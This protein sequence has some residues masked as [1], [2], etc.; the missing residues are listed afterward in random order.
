MSGSFRERRTARLA[1]GAAG[2]VLEIRQHVE[3][4]C[5]FD[6]G[7]QVV[8]DNPVVIAGDTHHQR[9]HR[10]EGLQCTEVR[11]CF[12]QNAAVRVNQHLG[13]Q[14]KPLLRTSGDQHLRCI[15]FPRQASGDH[16]AQG[17]VPFAGCV[18]QSRL[19]ISLA[20]APQHSLAGVGKLSNGKRLRRGQATGKTDDARL[21]RDF[22]NLADD[23]GVHLLGAAR[24]Q[25]GRVALQVIQFH[26]AS[27]CFSVRFNAAPR[28]LGVFT[29]IF[30]PRNTTAITASP[31][32]T[33]KASS[34][35]PSSGTANS[36][37]MN[38]CTNCT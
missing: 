32:P 14:V 7:C 12:D 34:V 28:P 24:K 38:G 36:I 29:G 19:P 16:F 31:K 10:G 8:D 30:L 5:A 11:G 6:L 22:Q 35:S 18:L 21:L 25:P 37:L 13:D 17:R 27:L 3:E 4:P 9:F 33:V 15:H 20:F 23:G 26:L 2:G 1:H